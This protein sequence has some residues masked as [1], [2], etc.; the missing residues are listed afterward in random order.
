MRM[1]INLCPEPQG[2]AASLQKAIQYIYF[3]IWSLML[4]PL[5]SKVL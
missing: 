3:G 1:T 4:L 5:K 2:Y